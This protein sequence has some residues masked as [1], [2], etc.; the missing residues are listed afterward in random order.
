MARE[1]F[2]ALK[3]EATELGINYPHNI[4]ESTLAKKVAAA[5]EEA[6]ELPEVED[7]N[8]EK[9]A[10][11]KTRAVI[12]HSND[13]ENEEADMVIGHKGELHKIQVG[14]KIDLDV[15]LIGVLKDAVETKHVSVLDKKGE[16]TGE[17]IE[18][19]RPRY[20]VEAV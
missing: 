16:P 14:E 3:E 4:T 13:R 17:I 9:P 8:E 19:P 6:G 20:I 2:E 10:K 5:K 7:E 1:E 18:K 11:K 12:I 15:E